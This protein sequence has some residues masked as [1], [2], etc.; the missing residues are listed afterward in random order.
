M[1]Q[2][3]LARKAIAVM[4]FWKA[5]YYGSKGLLIEWLGSIEKVASL[6]L[7]DALANSYRGQRK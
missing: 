1:S 3:R 4:Q 6:R 5:T 7:F 2:N